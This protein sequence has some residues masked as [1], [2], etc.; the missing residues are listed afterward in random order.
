MKFTHILG[1]VLI[2]GIGYFCFH[3]AANSIKT[4]EPEAAPE[5][6]ESH[7]LNSK[8][9]RLCG[10]EAELSGVRLQVVEMEVDMIRNL[11]TFTEQCEDDAIKEYCQQQIAYSEERLRVLGFDTATLK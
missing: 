1:F 9:R 8:L 10:E 4:P 3:M 6:F 5:S 7:L 11:T 2:I